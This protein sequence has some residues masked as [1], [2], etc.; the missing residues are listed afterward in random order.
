MRM[1]YTIERRYGSKMQNCDWLNRFDPAD[2]KSAWSLN[3]KEPHLFTGLTDAQQGL[4]RVEVEAADWPNRDAFA[5]VIVEAGAEPKQ[6]YNFAGMTDSQTH[7]LRRDL[8]GTAKEPCLEFLTYIGAW[9]AVFD[10]E[11]AATRVALK[12]G[13]GFAAPAQ[14]KWCPNI[15]KWAAHVGSVSP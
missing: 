11:L 2:K 7:Q 4:L 10:T 5:F 3:R 12:F 6:R 8:E 14:V 13:H 9:T 15:S 1:R